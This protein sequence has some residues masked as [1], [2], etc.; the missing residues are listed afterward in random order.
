MSFGLCQIDFVVLRYNLRFGQNNF[1][2]TIFTNELKK[3]YYY[4]LSILLYLKNFSCLKQ[5]HS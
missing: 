2:V 3:M 1:T 5:Q 4:I